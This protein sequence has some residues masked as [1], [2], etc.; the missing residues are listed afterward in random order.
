[1]GV[2]LAGEIRDKYKEKTITIISSSEKL[3]SPDFSER[4]DGKV[5]DLMATG[6]IKVINPKILA[7]PRLTRWLWGGQT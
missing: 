4:F 2:E 3:V 1:M 6:D 5:K 7:Q